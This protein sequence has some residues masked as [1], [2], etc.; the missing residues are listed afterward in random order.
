MMATFTDFFGFCYNNK[1]E[2]ADGRHCP[3]PNARRTNCLAC[4]LKL[5]GRPCSR[6]AVEA[7]VALAHLPGMRAGRV[8]GMVSDIAERPE[9][10]HRLYQRYA[11]AITPSAFLEQ[12]YLANDCRVPLRNVHFG[13]AID[14]SPKPPAPPR[15]ALRVGFIGQIAPHKGPDLLVEAIRNCRPGS[16]AC[17]IYGP[18]D[19]D[20]AFMEALRGRAQGL[21]V[22]FPGTFPKEEMAESW[23][24]ST[25]WSSPRAGTRTARWCC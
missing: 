17:R 19:Q 2:A 11:L 9:I 20:P 13:V 15:S 23:P 1:L 21:P 10:L 14:R 24:G 16:V 8:A 25:C 6:W 18:L 4:H 12:A 3:G 22:A 7:L 5:V